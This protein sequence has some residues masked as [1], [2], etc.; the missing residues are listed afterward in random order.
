MHGIAICSTF[1]KEKTMSVLK[2]YIASQKTEPVFIK[3]LGDFEVYTFKMK[4]AEANDFLNIFNTETN[5]ND[6]LQNAKKLA[7]MIVDKSGKKPFSIDNAD[8][9]ADL[10]ELPFDDFQAIANKFNEI[11]GFSLETEKKQ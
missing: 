5:K 11:N 4:V 2:N 1:Y 6:K 3:K 10:Q 8:D 9:L 7:F